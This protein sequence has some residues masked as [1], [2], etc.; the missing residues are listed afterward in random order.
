MRMLLVDDDR[1]LVTYVRKGFE[2]EGHTVTA[3]FDGS[4]G[5]K[6]AETTAFDIV[7][8]SVWTGISPS[9]RRFAGWPHRV[10]WSRVLLTTMLPAIV[11]MPRAAIAQQGT[12]QPIAPQPG[13]GQAGA[14]P[15]Y[16]PPLFADD[17]LMYAYALARTSG[18]PLLFKGEDFARMDVG[19]V[20]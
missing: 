9:L 20:I 15:T 16:R 19:R 4:A 8:L 3:C 5:L 12:A 14:P 11:L 10:R 17:T 7:V 2:E 6:A 1:E 13:T 18:E